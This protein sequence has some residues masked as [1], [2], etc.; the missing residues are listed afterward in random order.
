MFAFLLKADHQALRAL[1][2]RYLNT[3][4]RGTGVEYRP[5]MGMVG[6][7]CVKID[8]IS[9]RDSKGAQEGWMSEKDLGFWVPVVR[10][11]I[12]SDGRFDPEALLWFVP[13]MWVD[14]APALAEGREVY[15]VPKETGELAYAYEAGD[16]A[17][18]AVSTWA[19][20]KYSPDTE[21]H[22]QPLLEVVRSDG[23][24]LGELEHSFTSLEE[25][26]GSL[27]PS[28]A[29]DLFDAG[30]HL[31]LPHWHLLKNLLGEM[32]Q[33]LVPLVCLK[34]FRDVEQPDKA[35]FQSITETDCRLT[36]FH[37]GGWLGGDWRVRIHPYE[38]HPI[39]RD[40]GLSGPELT[41]ALHLWLRYDF[42]L[43]MGRTVW[44]AIPAV[45][46]PRGPEP[47]PAR[48]VS[49][50]ADDAFRPEELNQWWYWTG[51][52][53]SEDGRR[54]GF[55][56]AFFS[57]HLD[58]DRWGGWLWR[59]LFG[60]RL[61]DGTTGIQM[62]NF[63]ITDVEA[64]SFHSR[65]EYMPGIPRHVA[66]GFDLQTLGGSVR[67]IGGGGRDSL[68]GRVDRYVLDAQLEEKAPPV[69]QYGGLEHRYSFGGYTLYYSRPKLGVTGRLIVGDEPL[70]VTGTAWFDRQYGDLMN[71][72]FFGAG[73]DWFSLQLDDDTQIMLYHFHTVAN[74]AYG[75]VTH[76]DGQTSFLGPG[77]YTIEILD[78]WVS[79]HTSRRYPSR[80]KLDVQGRVFDVTP[81]VADQE[82]DELWEFPKYWEGACS[83][84]GDASGQAYVELTRYPRTR[85]LF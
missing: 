84:A 58:V 49:L 75:S 63:A 62:A 29:S 14:S 60:R 73:W 37:A 23:G 27:L 39:V 82:F 69:L 12:S 36:A 31:P 5:A 70:D 40:L 46:P 77:D 33:G 78:W 10:G 74:E 44:S 7:N 45:A 41:P 85:W 4:L 34:E 66:N 81:L 83:V 35:C 47:A 53:A 55:E 32:L 71:A 17:R 8:H 42:E 80:W 3:P 26:A 11:R 13:Y 61:V 52:L 72:A 51:H 68:Y 6:L 64:D 50:P 21:C 1:C 2:D 57:T 59:S 48:K 43:D 16:P 24:A 54:F 28:V 67:G 76:P 15:G 22:V 56:V 18:F 9:S 38:S 79:P 30:E 19:L 65:V 25:A 20:T